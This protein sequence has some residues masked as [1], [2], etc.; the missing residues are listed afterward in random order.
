MSEEKKSKITAVMVAEPKP[1]VPKPKP[2]ISKGNRP[3][4]HKLVLFHCHSEAQFFGGI[5]DTST[6]A[7]VDGYE[8]AP[9][10]KRE[11][12][13]HLCNVYGSALP[14]LHKI[15]AG[16]F[17]F[18]PGN[19]QVVSIDPAKAIIVN[20]WREPLI[21][22][23][24]IPSNVCP[25]TIR[26]L[27]LHVMGNDEVSLARFLNWLATIYQTNRPAGTA[28]IWSGQ[29]GTGK[30]LVFNEVLKPLFGEDYCV[31]KFADELKDA[32]NSWLEQ[33]VIFNIDEAE[34][35][36]A[37][38]SSMDAKLR[39]Y[40]T[41][42]RLSV[43]G[44]YQ[45]SREVSNYLSVI[46]TSNQTV[47]TD[48]PRGD[49]RF[50]VSPP[51]MQPITT[52]FANTDSLVKQLRAELRH[53]A[54][55]LAQYPVDAQLARTAMESS[56]KEEMT[57]AAATGPEEF[58]DALRS[59]NLEFFLDSYLEL[60]ET[61]SQYPLHT[62]RREHFRKALIAWLDAAPIG[63]DLPVPVGVLCDIYNV[64]FQTRVDMTP[65][66]LGRFLRRHGITPVRSNSQHLRG[67]G[68]LLNW[69]A[70]DGV[71]E[72]RAALT[73]DVFNS[74]APEAIGGVAAASAVTAGD[75]VDLARGVDWLDAPETTQ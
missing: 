65:E 26:A 32:F 7:F 31:Q 24:A 46:L 12:R 59:G 14:D 49:R 38:K 68:Y 71:D 43:R 4:S 70:P 72:Y 27:L 20:T 3:D 50:N 64:I 2:E 41:G 75:A 8:L 66:G 9:L 6:R 17:H 73:R 58:A 54:G 23:Q 22:S 69:N 33:C 52:R 42:E 18:E 48:L 5:Y 10:P 29:Q 63:R 37:A 51:Q 15:P 30:G 56:A 39:M 19:R 13:E 28:W 1:R 67:R 11:S 25:A 40:I 61:V 62:V 45:A 74:P 60:A 36:G 21:R 16:R 44:M 53:L 57:E 35:K 34:F 47:V 55:Y